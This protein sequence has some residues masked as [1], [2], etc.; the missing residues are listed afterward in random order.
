MPGY[1]RNEHASE[2]SF[3]NGYWKSGDIAS[4]DENGDLYVFMI[5]RKI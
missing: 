2:S 3:D 1:W 5:E 4:E